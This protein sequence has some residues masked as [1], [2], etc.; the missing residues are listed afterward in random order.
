MERCGQED[1][2]CGHTIDKLVAA[3]RGLLDCDIRSISNEAWW[4]AQDAIEEAGEK[5]GNGG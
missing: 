2:D 5:E 1:C 4:S 3:L